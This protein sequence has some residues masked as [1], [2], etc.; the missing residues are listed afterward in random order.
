MRLRGGDGDRRNPSIRDTTPLARRTSIPTGV[1]GG[2]ATAQI[3]GLAIA[4]ASGSTTTRSKGST[5]KG[6]EAQDGE[7]G[8]RVAS[9]CQHPRPW[10]SQRGPSP[11]IDNGAALPSA[12]G[13]NAVGAPRP[14]QHDI[15]QVP[16]PSACPPSSP[17][18][19]TRKPAPA[20]L[21]PRVRPQASPRS[22]LPGVHSSGARPARSRRHRSRTCSGP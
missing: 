16:S 10:Q 15:P 4:S 6:P 8:R 3:V 5:S 22:K 21:Q 13:E 18:H 14:R 2:Y 1:S 11:P 9:S 12:R 7:Q 19:F 17:Y 20:A